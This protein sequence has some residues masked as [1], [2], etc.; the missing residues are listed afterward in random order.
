MGIGFKVEPLLV[1]QH[2]VPDVA[3]AAEGLFKQLGLHFVGI[4]AGFDGAVLYN[5]PLPRSL[6]LLKALFRHSLFSFYAI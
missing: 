5:S 6:Y 4:E 3:A 1:S 2:P